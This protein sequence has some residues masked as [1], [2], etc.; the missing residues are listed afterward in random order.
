[1]VRRNIKPGNSKSLWD[2]VKIS[3]D[4]NTPKLPSK[5][6]LNN[7]EIDEDQL[8]DTFA[9]H[10]KEKIEKIIE[11][12]V[13]DVNVYNGN[14]KIFSNNEHFMDEKNIILAIKSLKSKNCE[15]HDRIPVRILIDGIDHLIKP[16]TYLFN[17][18][19]VTKT[20]PEQWL[21]S[22]VF[23]VHKKVRSTI[24]KTTDQFQIFALARKS[25]KNLSCY[26]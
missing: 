8:P 16:L 11:E 14:R 7:V 9:S 26:A 15:G 5:M 3:K 10:F 13:I 19:Y 2:A 1:M 25:L 23:P 20:I 22:K 12:Q 4:M 18:I 21:I 17:K 6:F 24:S